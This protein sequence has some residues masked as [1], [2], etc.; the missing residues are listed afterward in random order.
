VLAHSPHSSFS[1]PW[2]S[3]VSSSSINCSACP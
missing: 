2:S 3:I 1:P